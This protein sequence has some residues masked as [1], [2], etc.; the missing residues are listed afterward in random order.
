MGAI[1]SKPE[2]R[3]LHWEEYLRRVKD[4]PTVREPRAGLAPGC[5]QKMHGSMQDGGGHTVMQSQEAR[6]V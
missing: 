1:T 3:S 6:L 4:R 2:C 5:Y